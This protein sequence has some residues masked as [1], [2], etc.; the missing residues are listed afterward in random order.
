MSKDTFNTAKAIAD[1]YASKYGEGITFMCLSKTGIRKGFFWTLTEAINFCT[2]KGMYIMIEN[3]IP[4][5][6]VLVYTKE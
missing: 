5:N 2:K 6:S 4:A 3:K 1:E